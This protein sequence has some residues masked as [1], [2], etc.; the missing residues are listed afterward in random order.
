M[1]LPDPLSLWIDTAPAP[2]RPA[3]PLPSHADV[4]VV[5]AGIAGLTAA[6]RLAEAGRDVLVLEAGQVAGG[7]SGHTT[8]KVTAQH[9]LRY[10][11]LRRRKGRTAAAEYAAAQVDALEWIEAQVVGHGVD[12]GWER[13]P[14]YLYTTRRGDAETYA[15]EADAC[16]EAG[17]PVE[18][19]DDSP[20]PFGVASAL[21]M[22]GQAQFH[23]R[24]WLLHLADR[25]E[26]AGGRI[27]ERLR[28]TGAR[29][30]ASTVVTPVGEVTAQDVLVTTHYPVLDRGGFFA[31]L[32]PMRDLVV[33]GVVDPSRAPEGTYLCTSASR[34]I[35][36]TTAGDGS[37]RL[38]IGGENYRT[39]TSTAVDQRYQ[40]LAR[41]ALAHFGM[42]E[43]SHRWSAHDLVTPDGVP[44]VGSYLPGAEH[45][46][47]ATG[48]NLWGMTGGTAAGMLLADLVLGSADDERAALFSPNRA[49]VDQVPGVVR[50]NAV[51]AAHLV[52]DLG[53][54]SL[55][56]LD[57]GSLRPGE[58]QVGRDGTRI[59]GA[60]RDDD[61]EAHCVSAR[62]THL[63]CVVSFNDAERSWDCPCHGSRFG[64]D[65][66][67]LHGPAVRPL[68]RLPIG[69]DNSDNTVAPGSAPA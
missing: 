17:L 60:F 55:T 63:G 41:W 30:G 66:T 9:S 51:V 52:G 12:C 32:E 33:S 49:D 37:V 26:A 62:C 21:R 36:T 24:R 47:V 34:S 4:V 61:G 10:D 22:D 28:V 46:W 14:S 1:P 50:D 25:V 16:A 54:A 7:V 40:D 45:L 48:F 18:L 42:A 43:V 53:K 35:R 11:R 56:P 15:A 8:A 19:L 67:V 27:I 5:G 23:P 44:Y 3:H 65:G 68:D 13:V 29:D 59:V 2:D 39:G 57:L 6:C 20:L 64:L 31:R 69:P 58:A 38:L